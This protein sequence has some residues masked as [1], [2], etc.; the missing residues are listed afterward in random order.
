MFSEIFVSC[1]IIIMNGASCS[2]TRFRWLVA[3]RAALLLLHLYC[4][5]HCYLCRRRNIASTTTVYKIS[6]IHCPII[7][8]FKAFLA[9]LLQN[10]RLISLQKKY[11]AVCERK[12]YKLLLCTAVDVMQNI[13]L[14]H[15]L[16]SSIN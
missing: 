8:L 6:F 16:L 13:F 9:A 7:E 1:Y 11:F 10:V 2:D 4:C 15:A 14:Q 5:Y 3:R 12:N